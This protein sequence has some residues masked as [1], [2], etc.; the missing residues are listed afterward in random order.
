ML[1]LL[2]VGSGAWAEVVEN[3]ETLP[4][5]NVKAKRIA[6]QS[7]P[8]A[9]GR[10]AS[11]VVINGEKFKTRSATLGNAL[12][13]ELGV[14]S[15]PFGGGASAPVIRGQEGVRVK[16]LQ[17]GSDVVDMSALSPDHAVAADT[18]LAKQ[19]ELVRGTPTLMYAS[20][21]PAGVVNIVD[22]RIPDRVPVKGYEGEAVVRFDTASQEK[23]ST[24][25]ATL[26]V[27]DHI[28]IRAEGLARKSENYKVP[29]INLGE[30]LYYLPD[31]NNKSHVGTIGASWIGSKGYIGASYSHR[32]DE[33]G[34]P[35]HNHMFDPC[36]A[37]IFDI[38]GNDFKHY[39]Y[40]NVY[41]HLMGDEH[42]VKKLHFHCGTPYDANEP[43]NHN[44]V[45]GH[46][47]DHSG[48]G[49]QIE[50]RSKRYDLRGEWRKPF[51]GIDKFKASI[52]YADY[53][54]DELNDG[55]FY[56]DK[57]YGDSARK[58]KRKKAMERKGKPDAS[59]SNKGFNTR[60]ETYHTPIGNLKGVFGIQ[61]QTQKSRVEQYHE[62][63]FKD[64]HVLAPNT[65]KQFSLFAVEQYRLK[66]FIFE[67]GARWEKQ[68][69]PIHYDHDALNRYIANHENEFKK[70]ERPDLS[71][72]KQKAFSYSGTA[73][74]DFHPNYRLSLSASHN[75]RL[76]TPME[77]YYHGKHLATNSFEHGN[78]NLKKESSNNF[79]I[80]L[81]H[82]SEKW[83]YKISAYHN[84]FH[85]YIHNESLHRSGNLF[86]RRYNQTKA[87]FY[88]IEGEAGYR[89]LPGHKATVFGDYVRGKLVNLPNIYGDKIYGPGYDCT[90]ASGDIDTCYDLIGIETVHQPDRNAARVPPARLGFRLNSEFNERWS[91]S[92]EYTR[93]FA[94]NKTST[95]L[96]TKERNLTEEEEETGEIKSSKLVPVPILE[97]ATKGYHLVNAGIS[98]RNKLG[99]SKYTVSLNGNNLLN[100]KVYI[101]NSYLPY[102]PQMGR[103]FVFNFNL[104]F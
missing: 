70:I 95:S 18:L 32:K 27:G 74:W 77:L 30:K 29:G 22:N 55:K 38:Q 68:R 100:E 60:L 44:N 52:A 31:S 101:H 82:Q 92:L 98:Y 3:N 39:D 72:Y 91:G 5:V 36:S 41:P 19:V 78:K 35:G 20:A 73:L 67:A 37:H 65:N 79:E 26:G 46:K 45:Y 71:A 102:V 33:Y 2:A 49:P 93:V 42:M 64:R 51:P 56:D 23:A 1:S 21:S 59:F 53:F 50:M 4:E 10:K 69:I 99:K 43:H 14:H 63:F 94:Q 89:F 66:D 47:H 90:D 80:G 96:F 62:R 25:G 58:L 75:E 15:N 8:F 81:I 12:A 97:D 61:Y 54:H 83:D 40:L 86:I 24:V 48:P 85:N 17:N 9:Q 87:R 76:P 7:L 104:Q 28:A 103:N 13:G 16:I 6:N 34:I 11:D 88:G 57:D 84:R